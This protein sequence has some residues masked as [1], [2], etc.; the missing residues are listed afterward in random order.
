MNSFQGHFLV[1]APRQRDPNFV[2]AVVLVV[3]HNPRGAFG[4]I[5]ND[6]RAT[7][8]R[9]RLENFGQRF[10]EKFRACYGGPVAGPL[11]AVHRKASLGER[12]VLPGVFFSA[13]RKT[14][15]KLMWQIGRPCRVFMGYAGWGAGQLDFEIQHG[16]WRVV[17]A[18]PRQIFA[19]D[20][21]LWEQLSWQASGRQLQ[22]LFHIH[23]SHIPAY[24][25]LN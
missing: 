19:E 17:P 13:K 3:E 12:Q 6:A 9:F 5:V 25:G 11:M 7:G 10:S 23:H 2:K 20:D 21:R 4:V 14:V 22:S 1:A 15:L 18:A 8:G 16:T 24:P